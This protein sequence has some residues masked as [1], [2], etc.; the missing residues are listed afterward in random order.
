M[1]SQE[2]I[3][4][5]PVPRVALFTDSFHEVN[6]VALTSREFAKFARARFHPFFAVYPGPRTERRRR[7]SF[8]AFELAHSRALLRL[9]RDLA[10]DLLFFRHRRAV[11]RALAAFRPDL[12]HI[13]G[14][15]HIGMLG[16]FA[17]YDLRVPLVASWHTNVH[18][19]GS[20]RLAKILAGMPER[21]REP[22]TAFAERKSLDLVIR[23]YKLARMLFAPN[24][25]LVR[26]LTSRTGRPVRLMQRGIDIALFTPEKRK[27]VD[28]HFVIGYAGRLSPEKNVRMLAAFDRIL[29]EQGLRDYRFLIV[30]DGSE[31]AWLREHLDNAELPGLLQGEA[32][33]AA[34]AAMDVFVFPSETD[35]FGNVVLEAMASGVPV[36]ASGRGGPQ[37]LIEPGVTGFLASGADGFADAVLALASDSQR[38]LEMGRAARAAAA[39]RKWDAVFE[40]VYEDYRRGFAHGWLL[41]SSRPAGISP[42]RSG[43]RSTF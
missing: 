21:W 43:L 39:E 18:E 11:R 27:R 1:E 32:L 14:P 5:P 31:R 25:E 20:R 35:T 36:V 37:F 2:T 24:P 16:A 4:R 34:Y 42:M 28:A 3:S 17:A 7:G 41:P 9:E 40:G 19:F 23:F 26:M 38:R 22:V 8:E 33:A 10:F 15:G 12:V 6:G 30:G 13:T 29:K